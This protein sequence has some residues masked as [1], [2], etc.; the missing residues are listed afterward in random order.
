M[1]NQNGGSRL[2]ELPEEIIRTIF[3]FL[4]DD[5]VFVNLRMVNRR[6]KRIVDDY[7]IGMDLLM[8]YT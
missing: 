2:H 7:L 6:L 1:S 3:H 5:Q 4:P 8:I